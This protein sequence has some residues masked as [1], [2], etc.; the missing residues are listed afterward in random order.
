MMSRLLI[1]VEKT[2]TGFSAYLPRISDYKTN[3]DTNSA[4][5]NAPNELAFPLWLYFQAALAKYNL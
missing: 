1:F 2:G 5:I 3:R 4:F